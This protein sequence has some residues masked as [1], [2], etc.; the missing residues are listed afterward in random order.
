M[1]PPSTNDTRM[2]DEIHAASRSGRHL[3][4]R[5]P[6][7]RVTQDTLYLASQD[8]PT[9]HSHGSK[10]Q[11]RQDSGVAI[12][13]P[14]CQAPRVALRCSSSTGPTISGMSLTWE[15]LRIRQRCSCHQ[16]ACF[17]P[18]HNDATSESACAIIGQHQAAF[19]RASGHK[20][21][22]TDPSQPYPT[23]GTR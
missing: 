5:G 6:S 14:T 23:F 16:R 10:H 20:T 21:A 13:Y 8:P 2:P 3:I 12:R 17:Y 1:Y 15:W 22:A 4:T 11:H 18:C 9:T 7:V 19:P